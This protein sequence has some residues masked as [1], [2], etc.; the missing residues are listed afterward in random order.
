M[1]PIQARQLILT[2]INVNKIYQALIT[3]GLILKRPETIYSPKFKNIRHLFN[4]VRDDS[5][6][7]QCQA[8]PSEGV[9]NAENLEWK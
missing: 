1:T 4:H 8:D 7:L 3:L 6:I 9:Q 5:A 2:I